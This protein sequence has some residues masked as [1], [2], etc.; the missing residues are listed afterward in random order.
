MNKKIILFS[1]PVHSG[2]T[3]YL[4]NFFGVPC[5]VTGGFLTPDENGRRIIVNLEN[6]QKVDFQ[7]S[8][9]CTEEVLEVGKFRF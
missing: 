5:D 4:A 1:G 8:E 3:T 7:T 2:K 9:S 6:G